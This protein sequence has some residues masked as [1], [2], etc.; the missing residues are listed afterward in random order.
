MT[1]IVYEV[2][3]TGHDAPFKWQV[4]KRE[5]DG[6]II[7]TGRTGEAK[8]YEEA[9]FHASGEAHDLEYDRKYAATI[10]TTQL[11]EVDVDVAVDNPLEITD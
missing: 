7:R 1:R 9:L 6:K 5:P 8:T 2:E 3:V 4:I 11:F 10:R